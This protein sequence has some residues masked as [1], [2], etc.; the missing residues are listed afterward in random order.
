MKGDNYCLQTGVF[1]S[2]GWALMHGSGLLDK[3]EMLCII[4]AD[5]FMKTRLISLRSNCVSEKETCPP[6]DY[7]FSR[8]YTRRSN[9]I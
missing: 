7:E 4:S 5:S 8:S 9:H 2:I 6:F 1:S 3:C